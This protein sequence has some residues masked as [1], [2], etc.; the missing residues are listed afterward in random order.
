MPHRLLAGELDGSQ[1]SSLKAIR[2]ISIISQ[3]P[4]R[5]S[6]HEW[7]MLFDDLRPVWHVVALKNVNRSPG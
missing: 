7:P 4:S 3:E 1:E 6:P 5:G 2:R